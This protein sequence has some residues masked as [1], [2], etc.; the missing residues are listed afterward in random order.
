[1][2]PAVSG[3]SEAVWKRVSSK[4]IAYEVMKT[5]LTKRAVMVVNA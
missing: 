3:I 2:K 5:A 1:V 4:E